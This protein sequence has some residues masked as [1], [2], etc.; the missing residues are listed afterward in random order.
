M[1]LFTIVFTFL[2]FK[3]VEIFKSFLADVVRLKQVVD[4]IGEAVFDGFAW[5]TVLGLEELLQEVI[6]VS[7]LDTVTSFVVS[8]VRDVE[9]EVDFRLV[10]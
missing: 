1:L 7:L 2:R 8:C 6:A 3:L 10:G 9:A 5:Q 4:A